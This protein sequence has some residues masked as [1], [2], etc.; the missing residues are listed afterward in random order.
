MTTL[1]A[2]ASHPYAETT[3]WVLLVALWPT[4][5]LALLVA[6]W[7][8]S[9][10]AATAQAHY[11]VAGLALALCVAAV[12]GT[13]LALSLSA[14]RV[15]RT[16]PP[17]HLV[18]TGVEQHGPRPSRSLSV[19]EPLPLAV[20]STSA[21][22]AGS[23][24]GWIGLAWG[25]VGTSLLVVLIGQGVAV[26]RLRRNAVTCVN[27]GISAALTR[28]C[29]AHGIESEIRLLES[30]RLAAPVAL[31][32]RQPAILVPPRLEAAISAGALE[33][34]LAHEVA[35]VLHR[36]FVMNVLQRVAECV[37]CLCP[38]A[39]W[40]SRLIR[41]AREFRCDDLAVRH[42]QDDGVAYARALA[43][44][45]A[46]RP[47]TTRIALSVLGPPLV[48]RVRRLV[49][50]PRSPRPA[51]AQLAA[52]TAALV[53]SIPA[54]LPVL[55]EGR[56]SMARSAVAAQS[57]TVAAQSP[58]VV[59][60]TT[61]ARPGP[62]PD[63]LLAAPPAV[64]VPS[65]WAA[66]PRD[67]FGLG[68]AFDRT[69][70]T[71]RWLLQESQFWSGSAASAWP[72]A[73]FVAGVLSAI[74]NEEVAPD[75]PRARQA[76]E[77]VVGFLARQQEHADEPAAKLVTDAL[78]EVGLGTL[79]GAATGHLP[80]RFLLWLRLP[81]GAAPQLRLAD[82]GLGSLHYPDGGRFG[83]SPE[84]V[85]GAVDTV[86]IAILGPSVEPGAGYAQ[87]LESFDLQLDG[88]EV[89]LTAIPG[90]TLRVTEAPPLAD[91]GQVGQ[92]AAWAYGLFVTVPS[93]R[94]FAVPLDAGGATIPFRS[95]D[96]DLLLRPVM[97]EE[98]PGTADVTVMRADGTVLDTVRVRLGQPPAFTNS[99]PSYGV[100]IFRQQLPAG[101][102]PVDTSQPASAGSR[103]TVRRQVP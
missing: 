89:G 65:L 72:F 45:A 41:E 42:A 40:L 76:M 57:P 37:L 96:A 83:F 22:N 35:H 98:A 70:R 1:A 2:L 30:N 66:P 71:G 87:L 8:W 11:R 34:V 92:G 25:T 80:R 62:A 79:Q 5:A 55:A 60:P 77:A 36:D 32:W 69:Q 13:P 3:G 88:P 95:P 6:L 86:R 74:G 48:D 26:V 93:G 18:T 100:S 23:L 53:T 101:W 10:P 81:N 44:L 59:S 68:A 49:E 19:S 7:K 12:V 63:P 97:A 38:G 46:G 9:A 84:V 94:T 27:P 85:E 24:V 75:S 56:A 103:E 39:R 91:R 90:T 47:H 20:G 78:H 73:N 31:G 28:V 64:S 21:A 102:F 14:A 33:A 43:T 67:P 82:R 51:G 58:R 99:H 4:T 15:P 61:A 54:A 29:A 17:A 50:T 52:L 16:V